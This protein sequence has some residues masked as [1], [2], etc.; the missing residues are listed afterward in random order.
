[1]VSRSSAG[2]SVKIAGRIHHQSRSRAAAIV[3]TLKTV[4][5]L[6]G[7]FAPKQFA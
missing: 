5:N 4:K 6:L 7:P 3:P 2:G 1:M